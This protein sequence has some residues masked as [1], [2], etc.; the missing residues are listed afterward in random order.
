MKKKNPDFSGE[1]GIAWNTPHLP[2]EDG[3]NRKRCML[4][5][6][7]GFGGQGFF[8]FFLSPLCVYIVVLITGTVSG[9]KGY[10]ATAAIARLFMSK[11][12]TCSIVLPSPNCNFSSEL[13]HL[14]QKEKGDFSEEV[15]NRR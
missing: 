4:I 5:F 1:H 15:V 2:S 13:K 7:K 11:I 10:G 14:L 8:F 12:E 3:I 9:N 6:G